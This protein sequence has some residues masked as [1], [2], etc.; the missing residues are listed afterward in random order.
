M[1]PRILVV[2]PT[3]NRAGLAQVA[4][5][6]VLGQYCRNVRVLVSDNSTDPAE[7]TALRTH[8]ET[9]DQSIVT[10]VRPARPLAMTAHWEWALR[11]GLARPGFTHVIY[12]TDRMVLKDGALSELAQLAA[13]YPLAVVSY[14]HDRID[15][16]RRPVR[17][18]QREWT[19]RLFE[20]PSAQLLRLTARA[21]IP[22]CLPRMLN[23]ISPVETLQVLSMRFGSVFASVSPDH[24]FAYRLLATVDAIL[25]MDA[26]LMIHYALDRSNGASYARGLA[27]QDHLDFIANLGDSEL[28]AT[29]PIPAFHTASNPVFSEYEFVRA[30]TSSARFPELDRFQYLGMM[31]F[32]ARRLRDPQLAQAVSALLRHHGWNGAKRAVWLLQRVLAYLRRDPIGAVAHLATRPRAF[33][34]VPAGLAWANSHP[35]RPRPRA[36]HFYL[37]PLM[38]P[39][40]LVRDVQAASR[41]SSLSRQRPRQADEKS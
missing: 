10:Y 19:G 15:D 27:S 7:V 21:I 2:I 36:V 17:L 5:A 1:T 39:P 11:T 12:L 28:N 16:F 4:I 8:C 37:W 33:G 20:I 41:R 18:E 22:P 32:D 24:A 9:L 30:E 38:D 14:N 34:S 6:S 23:C 31:D 26:T 29:A 25:Y 13:Q 40:G 35:R 3:R